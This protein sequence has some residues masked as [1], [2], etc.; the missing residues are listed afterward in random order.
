MS[1]KKREPSRSIHVP[2]PVAIEPHE[3]LRLLQGQRIRIHHHQIGVPTAHFHVHVSRTKAARMSKRVTAGKGMHLGL[4]PAEIRSTGRRGRGFMDF[5]KKGFNIA[6]KVGGVVKKVGTALAPVIHPLATRL[7]NNAT[8]FLPGPVRGI[9]QGLAQR[10]LSELTG[11]YDPNAG[12]EDQAEDQA[13]DQ[14]ADQVADQVADQAGIPVAPPVMDMPIPPPPPVFNPPRAKIPRP[15]AAKAPSGYEAVLDEMQNHPRFKNPVGGGFTGKNAYGPNSVAWMF[16]AL[17]NRL[18]GATT[19]KGLNIHLHHGKRQKSAKRQ[20]NALARPRLPAGSVP[21]YPHLRPFA[22][23]ASAVV[24]PAKR[25]RR[26]AVV[27]AAENAA[28]RRSSRIN[29]Q[30]GSFFLP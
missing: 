16:P 22:K 3:A 14:I 25:S 13:T 19:G 27:A 18:S 24:A 4:S 9:A 29:K 1:R 17:A 26:A 12:A 5:L 10:G 2:V 15:P 8:Q 21:G 30:G 6:K 23:S 28:P 11:G 7:I 20:Q